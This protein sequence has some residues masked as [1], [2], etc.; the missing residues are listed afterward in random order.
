MT[1]MKANKMI[2]ALF[3]FLLTSL[4]IFA[5]KNEISIPDVSVVAGKS[6]NL[7]IYLDNSEDIIAI[8]FTLELADGFTLQTS[9]ANLTDRATDHSIVMKEVAHNKYMAMIFSPSNSSIIGRTGVLLYVPLFAQDTMKDTVS[10]PMTLSDVIIAGNT[11]DNLMTNSHVGEITIAASADFEVSNVSVNTNTITPNTKMVVNWQVTNIGGLPAQAG[12]KENIYLDAPN[13]YSK[14]IGSVYYDEILNVNGVVSRNA[15]L[16]VPAELGI[17]GEATIRVKL[18]ANAD[19]GEYPWYSFNNEAISNNTLTIQKVLLLQPATIHLNEKDAAVYRWKLIRSGSAHL[20]ET[21]TLTASEDARIVLPETITI[22]ASQSGAYIDFQLTANATLDSDS[23]VLLRVQGDN[24]NETTGH[25]II[26]DDTYPTLTVQTT[27]PSIQEGSDLLLFLTAQRASNHDVEI[28]ITSDIMGAFDIPTSV[29]LPAG[30]TSMEIRIPTIDDNMPNPDRT[31]TLSLSAAQYQSTTIEILLSDND[32]PELHLILTPNAISEA[33]GPLSVAAKITR[34]DNIDKKL[35]LRL[36]DDSEGAI[37]YGRNELEMPAGVEEI[38]VNVGP[39]DNAVVD[40]E[41]TYNITAAIYSKSCSCNATS[42]ESMGIAT[43]PLTIYDNDG[44]TLAGVTSGSVLQEWGV[45]TITVSHNTT[46]DKAITVAISSDHSAEL[47]YPATVLIPAG[48]SSATFDVKSKGNAT[49]SDDYTA[50]LT[51]SAEGFAKTN[52]WFMV[53]DQTLPDAQIKSIAV[54]QNEVCPGDTVNLSITLANIGNYPLAEATKI[55]FY[56]NTQSLASLVLPSALMNGDSLVLHCNA[57]IPSSIGGFNLYAQVNED[58]KVKEL[59]YNNNTSDVLPMALVS[60]F[61]FDVTTDKAVYQQGDTVTISGQLYGNKTANQAIELYVINDGIRHKIPLTTD[62]TGAF[63]TYYTPVLGQMGRFVVGACYPDEN[64]RDKL[65][66][67]DIY[68]IKRTGNPYITCETY[69]NELYTRS[70][71]ILNPST[72]PLTGVQATVV[73][74][75]EHCQVEI[76]CPTAIYAGQTVQLE[77]SILSD[78]ASSGI[79]WEK[80]RIEVTTN[81]GATLTTTLFHYCTNHIA[82]LKASVSAINTTMTF[83]TSRTYAFTIKNIGKGE[84]G[85]IT[86]NPPAWMGLYTPREMPSLASG[87]TATII[88]KLQPTEDMQLNNPVCGTIG[89]NCEN[90]KG[91][92]L[93]YVVEPVSTTTGVLIVDVCD[94]NTYYTAEAPHLQGAKVVISHPTRGNTIAEG[95]TDANGL[96]TVEL[97]EGYYSIYVTADKHESYRNN[98]LIDPGVENKLHVNIGIEAITYTWTVEETE[99][100]DEYEIITTVNYETNVPVPV[101]VVSMPDSLPVEDMAVG[102][103]LIFNVTLTNKG[104]ITAQ[105]VQLDLPIDNK[106]VALEQLTNLTP[107]AIEPNRSVVIP[108]KLTVLPDSEE[109]EDGNISGGGSTKPEP[110]PEPNPK[111]DPENPE[112]PDPENP[113]NP[114]PDNPENPNPE[115]PENPGGENPNPNDPENPNTPPAD[116]PPSKRKLCVLSVRTLYYT[117]CEGWHRRYVVY[118]ETRLGPCPK[119]STPTGSYRGGYSSSLDGSGFGGPGGSGGHG[120]GGFYFGTS[121]YGSIDVIDLSCVPCVNE[122]GQKIL[123]CAIGFL[124]DLLSLPD[125]VGCILGIAQSVADHKKGET[126]WRHYT[127]MAL[128]GIGCAAEICTAVAGPAVGAVCKGIGYFANIAGCLLPFTEPCGANNIRQKVQGAPARSTEP[129]WVTQFREANGLYLEYWTAYQDILV[130]YFGDRVWIEQTT[131]DELYQLLSAIELIQ[132]NEIRMES[133]LEFKPQNITMDQFERFIQRLNN[134]ELLDQTKPVETNYINYDS[135][136]VP[137]NTI[138]S[139]AEKCVLMGYNSVEDMWKQEYEK[140]TKSLDEASKSICSTISL[141]ISQQMVMTRQAFRGTLTVFNGSENTAMEN[142]KLTLNVTDEQGNVATSHEF[143]INLEDLQGFEGEKTLETGWNLDAQQEGIATILFIPTKYAAPTVDRVYSFGGTLSYIDPFT[144]LEVTR[145]LHPVSL[146]VKPSPNLDLTYFMQRDVIGDDPLTETIEP[147]EEAEFSLLINNVGYGDAN[148]VRI[149]TNQPEIIDNE[150][151]LL[152]DFEIMS[153]QLNGQEKVLALGGSVDTD[154][155]NIP[156]QSTSYAQWWLRSSLL[157]HFTEYNVEATHVTSYGNPDLSLLNE[158]TIHELIRSI[159]ATSNNQPLVGF[160]AND[161]VDAEDMP[162]MMYLSNGLVEKVTIV[163]SATITKHSDEAYMLTVTPSQ[164]GWNYGSVSDPT[165]GLAQLKAITRQSDSKSISLR[166]IWQTD[167]TL[168]DGK[169]PLYENRIHFV[170][171]IATTATESYL[172]TFEPTPDLFLEISSFNGVPAEGVV[173]DKTLDKLMVTFNKTIDPTTFTAEDLTLT[174]EGKKMDMSQVLLTTKDNQTFTID[175]SKVAGNVKNGYHVLFIQ[176]NTISDTEG[177]TGRNGKSTNW[178]AYNADGITLHTSVYPQHAGTIKCSH[179]GADNNTVV[180]NVVD[181]GTTITLTANPIEGYNFV[182][183]TINGEE[184]SSASTM[185]YVVLGE[186]VQITANFTEKMFTLDVVSDII[187]GAIEGV[188]SGIYPFGTTFTIQPSPDYGYTFSHWLI[189]DVNVGTNPAMDISV[190]QPLTISAQFVREIYTQRLVTY[191]GWN[192][193]SSYLQEPIAIEEFTDLSNHIVSQLD[194]I[195]KDPLYGFIGGISSLEGGVAYKVQSSMA[196]ARVLEGHLY[197]ASSNP[198]TLQTGWN[199]IGYPYHEE[200][201]L[202][203]I[204]NPAEGDYITSQEG[205]AEFANGYWQGSISLLTPGA[206]YLYKSVDNKQLTY[207]FTPHAVPA[208]LPKKQMAATDNGQEDLNIR[209]YPNTMNVTAKLYNA[210]HEMTNGLYTIYAMCGNECR[211]IGFAVGD[212]YYITIYGDELVDISFVIENQMSGE[213]YVANEMLQFNGD[214][215][216]SRNKP[217]II[218]V[219]AKAP[220]GIENTESGI[221][222]LTIYTVLGVLLNENAS[223]TDLQTLP[224]GIY[225]VGGQK[226]YV[227]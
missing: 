180:S 133:L 196:F 79:D 189:N 216:G 32:I 113:E 138:M 198:I 193:L 68:G 190:D 186:D 156:A 98:L 66:A 221:Q 157:G 91:L 33:A 9:S 87:D 213:T 223:L 43:A 82:T 220:T 129:D 197:D 60:P 28:K 179:V 29:I 212:Y 55:T 4:S 188:V 27:T 36:Y 119:G 178:L 69:V 116:N 144:G 102:E 85:K 155:G 226:Y 136:D 108:V 117:Y 103:S 2:T 130:E 18:V 13:G 118:S 77:Y 154:F 169:E 149:T 182:N 227:K 42:G 111:P 101:V 123:G 191:Q 121:N 97:P 56:L 148:N 107:F 80:I 132:D 39:I 89:I 71:G 51:L 152:I 106:Y 158:V 7:P 127:G 24:Y 172:L 58:K 25:I 218:D 75:P 164:L 161:I 72:L 211:G 100:E 70:F 73:S 23:V 131:V 147:C 192:W 195:I 6:I 150:K 219:A 215:V 8:Q 54:S 175:L 20:P 160:M 59:N 185:E 65:A 57:I 46:T 206:G 207:D 62:E 122:I 92:A 48:Q 173:L 184:V 31:C 177:F 224:Q 78:T 146:T 90:G 183:W 135:F 168:R 26:T 126:G 34:K 120:G 10:Y 67:F 44:A 124:P 86:I 209:Q 125:G 187:G 203:A 41:R 143:Q 194:E 38:N 3:V 88:L 222:P 174:V 141:K 96:F 202:S 109:P 16:V 162:D 49:T 166:N 104:L 76:N 105:D 214:V 201:P 30:Q 134:T 22:P 61:S 170:D 163:Q 137:A 159:D 15:E 115:N 217:Y 204:Q 167:R 17:D 19:A 52:V 112:S 171:D 200:R 94:E 153:A 5:Q 128:T 176:T 35:T 40:G 210:N 37:Y 83:G 45:I 199:W 53:S 11:G 63:Q 50:I 93:R 95:V 84:T 74:K 139:V 208:Y 21:F 14:Y 140:M 151:G 99:V 114:D 1:T 142:V 225:I 64:L 165:Y 47:E 110:E 12:W 181:Y 81:E 145:T 205:F